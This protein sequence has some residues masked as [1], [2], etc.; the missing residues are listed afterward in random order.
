MLSIGQIPGG[1]SL[2]RVTDEVLLSEIPLVFLTEEPF[3]HRIDG[4]DG[5][6]DHLSRS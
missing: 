6:E 2:Y 5:A 3:L 1:K 4:I